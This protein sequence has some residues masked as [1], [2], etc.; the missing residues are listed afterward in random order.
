[1]DTNNGA[2]PTFLINGRFGKEYFFV[3]SEFVKAFGSSNYKT[4]LTDFG[5]QEEMMA[6]KKMTGQAAS[7]LDDLIRTRQKKVK[8]AF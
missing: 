6:C 1:M 3:R 7:I 5:D 8:I 2:H 4:I